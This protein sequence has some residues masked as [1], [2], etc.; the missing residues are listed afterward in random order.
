VASWPKI[1]T[2]AWD[3][4]LQA[5]AIEN[6]SYTIGVNRIGTDANGYEYIG[7]S[8]V[9]NFLGNYVLKPEEFE[10]VFIVVIEKEKMVETRQRLGFLNDRDS[11]K[12][13][14]TLL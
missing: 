5:R 7:H 12:I 2:N 1:R 6:M 13:K 10:G 8:Q 14:N 4:L 11:F 3:T 9:V